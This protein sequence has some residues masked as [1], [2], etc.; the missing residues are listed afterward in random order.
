[1]GADGAK[2]GPAVAAVIDLLK[3]GSCAQPGPT[4]RVQTLAIFMAAT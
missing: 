3:P 2:R 4:L 1:M